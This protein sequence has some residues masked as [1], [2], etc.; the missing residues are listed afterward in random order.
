MFQSFKINSSKRSVKSPETTNFHFFVVS[1]LKHKK[2]KFHLHVSE[3][4]DMILYTALQ[5]V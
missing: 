2:Y 3:L 5:V 1:Y 4:I